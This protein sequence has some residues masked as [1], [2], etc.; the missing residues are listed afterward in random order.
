MPHDEG[1]VSNKIGSNLDA[2][3]REV[4]RKIEC[5]QEGGMN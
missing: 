2:G 4:E 3:D 1:L 5:V